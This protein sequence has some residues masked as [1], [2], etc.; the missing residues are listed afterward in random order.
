LD[1]NKY[2]L[3]LFNSKNVAIV[4]GYHLLMSK[5]KKGISRHI[6]WSNKKARLKKRAL[7]YQ[8]ILAKTYL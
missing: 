2:C 1:L 4:S 7:I 8:K 5:E 6:L 3:A